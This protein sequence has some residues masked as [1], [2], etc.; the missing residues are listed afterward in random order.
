MCGLCACVLYLWCL[1]CKPDPCHPARERGY[2]NCDVCMM[3]VVLESVCIVEGEGRVASIL[4]HTSTHMH[5]CTHPHIHTSTHAHMHTCTHPHMHTCTHAHMHTCTQLYGYTPLHL[6]CLY[7]HHR[8]VMELLRKLRS[9]SCA[10][11][12][13]DKVTATTA[14]VPPTT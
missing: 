12:T 3:F 1:W 14:S 5:T 11:N 7:S 9:D 4:L 10:I 8:V 6:A 2:S 13:Q